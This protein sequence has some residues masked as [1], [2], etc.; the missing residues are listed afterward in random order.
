MFWKLFAKKDKCELSTESIQLNSENTEKNEMDGDNGVDSDYIITVFLSLFKKEPQKKEGKFPT[1]IHY[2]LGIINE[3]QY[4]DE[5]IKSQFIEPAPQN[6]VLALLKV[7]ELREILENNGLKK[8]GNKP[9]LVERIL[10]EADLSQIQI[11]TESYYSL[12]Q[13]GINFL[14]SHNDFI[15]IRQNSQWGIGIN[16]YIQMKDMSNGTKTFDD[17]V[18]SLLN[19]KLI[20]I[21]KKRLNLSQYEYHRL[22]EIYLSIYQLL[23]DR[24]E[25]QNAIK[26][27]L[28]SLLLSV[29]G[30]ENYWLI[31]YKHGLRLRNAEVL[32]NYIPIHVN[33]FVAM[34]IIELKDYYS[35]QVA[36]D[37][38]HSFIGPFN[39]CTLEMFGEITK[40][41]FISTTTPNLSQYDE[42]IKK[43]FIKKL[44]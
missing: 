12:S 4:F 17:I 31:G 20:S 6:S 26:P 3:K 2:E 43:E 35:E 1:Y 39:L 34:N 27:L 36:S 21:K 22:H 44:K 42:I 10:S 9:I 30:C 37:I 41:V 29:S 13:K 38:Y 14:K 18:L 7:S 33:E 11:L 8:T 16:E 25:P 5:M 40:K 24:Q 32:K 28:S 15:R 19:Q 23:Q